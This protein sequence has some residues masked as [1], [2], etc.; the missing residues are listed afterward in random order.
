MSYR[1]PVSEEDGTAAPKIRR[2]LVLDI[3]IIGGER[4]ALLAF[5]ISAKSG[6]NHGYEIRVRSAKAVRAAGLHR[7]TRFIGA[8]RLFVPLDGTGF[9]I[10]A[11]TGAPV[12]GRLDETARRR[13]NAV[14]PHPRRTRHRGRP[15]RLLAP[16]VPRA[17]PVHRRG[18]LPKRHARRQGG[19]A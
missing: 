5:G 2:C 15:T 13:M 18:P 8:R 7:S 4:Y 1:F 9:A 17:A 14:R 3:E 11:A 10:C 19:A 6:A 12:L 16:Q